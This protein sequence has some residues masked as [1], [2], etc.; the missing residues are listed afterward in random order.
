MLVTEWI[1]S[2]HLFSISVLFSILILFFLLIFSMTMTLHFTLQMQIGP[3]ISRMW[4]YLRRGKAGGEKEKSVCGGGVMSLSLFRSLGCPFD[5][6]LGLLLLLTHS[7]YLSLVSGKL[8]EL[9]ISGGDGRTD[10]RTVWVLFRKKKKK[11]TFSNEIHFPP[12]IEFY[13]I[14]W[15]KKKKKKKD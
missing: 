6:F 15:I 5:P 13:G 2:N 9:S 11:D 14:Y 1:S 8:S 3:R 10:R 4:E 7:L 12:S